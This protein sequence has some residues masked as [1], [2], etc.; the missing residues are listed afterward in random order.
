MEPRGDEPRGFFLRETGDGPGTGWH[1]GGRE[2][3]PVRGDG[4]PDWSRSAFP[5]GGVFAVA[6]VGALAGSRFFGSATR[7]KRPATGLG[8][9]V[10]MDRSGRKSGTRRATASP[11]TIPT[12]LPGG[13]EAFRPDED[14]MKRLYGLFDAEGAAGL[15]GTGTPHS[16]AAD[17]HRTGRRL[18]TRPG[19]YFRLWMNGNALPSN[20]PFLT[21]KRSNLAPSDFASFSQS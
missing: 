6:A 9:R 11:G 7:P 16:C 1:A 18:T 21:G 17:R 20:A 3:P 8:W 12:R 4:E 14:G 2:A 5:K 15:D 13:V 10:R 19:N